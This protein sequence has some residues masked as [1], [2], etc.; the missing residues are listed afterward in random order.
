MYVG[1]FA[2]DSSIDKDEV[3]VVYK[4]VIYKYYACIRYLF[5]S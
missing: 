4:P 1:I 3:Q 2:L 5:N